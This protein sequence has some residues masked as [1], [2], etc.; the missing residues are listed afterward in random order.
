MEA[1]QLRGLGGGD[2][3][4]VNI[5]PS[6]TNRTTTIA[7]GT[8]IV[9]GSGADTIVSTGT[10]NNVWTLTGRDTGS[11]NGVTF[12]SIRNLVG[13]GADDSFTLLRGGSL[14]GTVDGA[15]GND[16]LAYV[17]Q[18]GIID[19]FVD[20]NSV[21]ASLL[22]GVVSIE[23]FSTSNPS[24]ATLHS[25]AAP[26]A[27]PSLWSISA[28]G[29]TL[30]DRQFVGFGNLEG[31]DFASDRFEF[32]GIPVETYAID[33]GRGG[34]T[35]DTIYFAA[36]A[37][38]SDIN[39]ETNS[40]SGISRFTGIEQ[41]I[42]DNYWSSLVGPRS[43]VTWSIGEEYITT[44]SSGVT[45]VGFREL[46]GNARND[47]FVFTP[48]SY[49]GFTRFPDAVLRGG[50]GSD[51]IVVLNTGANVDWYLDQLGGGRF[52]AYQF[53][54]IENLSSAGSINYFNFGDIPSVPW[55]ESIQGSAASGALNTLGYSGSTTTQPLLVDL[56]NKT[57]SGVVTI[58]NLQWFD[59]GGFASVLKGPNADA[60]WRQ[61]S[62][63][64]VRL[65]DATFVNFQS[66]VGGSASDTI[67]V[68]IDEW[69]ASFDGGAGRN[70]LDYSAHQQLKLTWPQVLPRSLTWVS[71]T[72]KMFLVLLKT[73]CSLAIAKTTC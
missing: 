67:E 18:A 31:S 40:G 6:T 45:I 22:G 39:L 12:Q 16:Q 26:S 51:S 19:V 7:P 24:R 38:F 52:L 47:T 43:N 35:P 71:A 49:L 10:G 44:L 15:G 1:R 37:G 33:G 50:A 11:L 36:D 4:N 64:L 56:Q 65:G 72:S 2:T 32:N 46:I 73:I 34:A 20:R 30:R 21:A 70:T 27:G 59:A 5:S 58:N 17:N 68:G 29:V 61:D 62:S 13:N 54:N 53:T 9:G 63:G 55:F 60:I 23:T 25:V 14:S 48:N 8:S 57:A 41:F 28:G 66:I 3:F 69:L 42:T